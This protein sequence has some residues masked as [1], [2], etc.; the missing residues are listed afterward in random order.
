MCK[1]FLIKKRE[2]VGIKH[3]NDPRAFEKYSQSSGV[4]YNI[5]MSTIWVEKEKF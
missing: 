4:V 3:L 2:D 5:L 1:K